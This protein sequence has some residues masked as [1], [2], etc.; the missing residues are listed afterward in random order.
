[1]IFR[2][3]FRHSICGI[4][5]N[6]LVL[7][8]LLLNH[9]RPFCTHR[10]CQPIRHLHS[11]DLG[12]IPGLA[13]VTLMLM[14]RTRGRTIHTTYKIFQRVN[15]QACSI[16]DTVRFHIADMKSARSNTNALL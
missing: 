6:K 5:E 10:I 16:L 9:V 13:M 3:Y 14:S 4:R 2:S 7:I 11:V 1:M 8:S 12:S 15:G